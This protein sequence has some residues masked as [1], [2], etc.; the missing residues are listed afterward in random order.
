MRAFFGKKSDQVSAK[1]RERLIF[2]RLLYA[3]QKAVDGR[4]VVIILYERSPLFERRKAF[5]NNFVPV[6]RGN[7]AVP[8]V[9][10]AI[11]HLNKKQECTNEARGCIFACLFFY[12]CMCT[13]VLRTASA[14]VLWASDILNT[15]LFGDNGFVAWPWLSNLIA[16]EDV[17]APPNMLWLWYCVMRKLLKLAS[18]IAPLALMRDNSVSEVMLAVYAGCYALEVPF[19]NVP[20]V[21][22]AIIFSMIG[23]AG[24]LG[25][26]LLGAGLTYYGAVV[27]ILTF[28]RRP[29][30]TS[31][32]PALVCMY[33]LKD[34]LVANNA[35]ARRFH[36]RICAMILV[37]AP[38]INDAERNDPGVQR[39][40]HNT[41]AKSLNLA[42]M[43]I[44]LAFTF[45]VPIVL[46]RD[47]S[48]A[49]V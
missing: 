9:T 48:C 38:G 23:D 35:T 22:F 39:R 18:P 44:A 31:L 11:R 32:A 26:I 47:N 6:P 49:I 42:I 37:R 28:L 46:R 2:G 36:D 14:S 16:Y 1:P 3:P 27:G 41:L 45:W 34:L 33:V 13:S 10:R 30:L 40:V 43:S 12:Q 19:I 8:R 20:F 29:L 7:K 5:S 4:H 15:P 24:A 17:C 25:V 21:L